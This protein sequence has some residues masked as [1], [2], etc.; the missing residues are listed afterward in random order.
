MPN[1]TTQARRIETNK[2]TTTSNKEHDISN[3]KQ[4]A[5][6]QL[7]QTINN[8]QINQSNTKQQHKTNAQTSIHLPTKKG[9]EGKTNIKQKHEHVKAMKET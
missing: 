6:S 8:K 7:Q 3:N 2:E 5:H 4:E 9:T 1:K